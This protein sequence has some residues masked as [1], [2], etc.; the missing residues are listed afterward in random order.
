MQV[1]TLSGVYENPTLIPPPAPDLLSLVSPAFYD[2]W[3]PG[4]LQPNAMPAVA[5]FRASSS[6]SL[7]SSQMFRN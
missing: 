4:F 3:T 2:G 6:R 5:T 1:S 7:L